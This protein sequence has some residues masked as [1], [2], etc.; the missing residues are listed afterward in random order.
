M[1]SAAAANSAAFWRIAGM[2]YLSYANKC[3]EIVRQ[4]LKEPFLTQV[5]AP[6]ARPPRD[7]LTRFPARVLTRSPRGAL[8]TQAKARETVYY[9]MTEFAAGKPG[10]AGA[11]T[12]IAR[13]GL[14][15]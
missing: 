13:L 12:P 11:S 5:R 1:S 10:K 8:A 9:K 4:S 15:S 2:S 3:G 7:D 14:D 6:I